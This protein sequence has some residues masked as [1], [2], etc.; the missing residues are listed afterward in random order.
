MGNWDGAAGLRGQKK[1]ILYRPTS[2][3]CPD[4]QLSH[5]HRASV[6]Q[7]HGL[8]PHTLGFAGVDYLCYDW[9]RP[10]ILVLVGQHCD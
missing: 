10:A 8:C 1:M 6:G 9:I 2:C 7:Y 4:A 5:L 3:A